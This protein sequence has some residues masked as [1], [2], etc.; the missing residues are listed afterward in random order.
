MASA[1][2]G[3]VS[4]PVARITLSQASGGR[5]AIS[6][7][8]DGDQRMGR[9]CRRDLVRKGITIHGQRRPCRHLVLVRHAHDQRIQLAHFMVDQS[10]RVEV[11]IIRPERVRTDQFGKPLALVGLGHADRAHFM[12]D[13]RDAGFGDLPGGF[14]AGKAAADN[15]DGGNNT[16]FHAG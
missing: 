2:A 10:D 9:Q 4:G 5:P 12:E 13:D 1:R 11:G 15:M 8:F 14:T 7:R 6:P 3:E 16:L